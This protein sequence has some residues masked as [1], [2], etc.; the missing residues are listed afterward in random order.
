MKTMKPV[1]LATFA[2]LMLGVSG[3]GARDITPPGQPADV[4]VQEKAE[5]A[6]AGHYL[7]CDLC[8]VRARG[9]NPSRD[10]SGL[11]AGFGGGG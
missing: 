3:A 11:D 8:W 10:R 4:R 2:T 7:G 9:T 5:S 6:R 1:I